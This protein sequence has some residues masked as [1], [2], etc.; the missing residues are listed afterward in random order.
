MCGKIK[1][2]CVQLKDDTGDAPIIARFV[3]SRANNDFWGS[4]LASI[5]DLGVVLVVKSGAA[6]VNHF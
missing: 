4:V 2:P 1:F 5:D 3:P 6:E